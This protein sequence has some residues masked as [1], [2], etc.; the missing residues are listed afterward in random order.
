MYSGNAER[1]TDEAEIDS[2]ETAAARLELVLP[3]SPV[4]MPAQPI[5]R[6]EKEL[7]WYLSDNMSTD[8]GWLLEAEEEKPMPILD[9]ISHQIDIIYSPT[10]KRSVDSLRTSTVRLSHMGYIGIKK[11]VPSHGKS[12]TINIQLLPQGQEI[13]QFLA[14]EQT[15]AKIQASEAIEHARLNGPPPKSTKVIKPANDAKPNPKLSRGA[16]TRLD[17]MSKDSFWQVGALVS[18]EITVL[19]QRVALRRAQRDGRTVDQSVTPYYKQEDKLAEGAAL[20]E[21]FGNT[22]KGRKQ[23]KKHLEQLYARLHRLTGEY[24]EIRRK[25]QTSFMSIEMAQA[26]AD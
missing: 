18:R 8:D 19:E 26:D 17:A 7:L 11:A 21:R 14:T 6:R 1:L 15:T 24:D 23:Y 16:I 22:S 20:N 5:Y 2:I 9:G 3:D 25:P 13:S 10:Q 12:P 4:D